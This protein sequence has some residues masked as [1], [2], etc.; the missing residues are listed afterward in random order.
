[1][2]D[3]FKDLNANQ[4]EA[5]T[6][7]EGRIRLVAGAG[8]GKTRTLAHRFAYLANELGISAS[9]IL[10]MTFTNKAA[11]EM[12]TRIARLVNSTGNVNDFV[13]TIHG[14]CVKVL[15][16]EIH[17]LGF[18]DN[19]VILDE[20]DG[21]E[22]AKQVIVDLGLDKS[23]TTAAKVLDTVGASKGDG[24]YVELMFP[25]RQLDAK[26]LFQRYLQLQVKFFAVDFDDLL[27]F[28]LY[29]FEH[30]ADARAY[31]QELIDYV[32]IDEAQDCDNLDWT[33]I[34]LLAAKN[35]NLLAVGDPDQAIYE[36]RGAKPNLFINFDADRTI[37]LNQNYRSTPDILDVANSVIAH[38]KNRIPKELFTR[39]L[40][41][42]KVIHYHGRSEADESAWVTRQVALLA[43]EAG[44]GYDDIAILFRTASLSRP[45]EQALIQ[46]KVPYV[47][48]GGVRFFERREIKDALGY[49]KLV[50]RRDDM[51]FRRVVN[52]PSR[53]FGRASLAKLTALAEAEGASL[54]DT[55]CR[56][57]GDKE[58][59]RPA[60][61]AFCDLITK[62]EELKPRLSVSE[63]L[64]QL[65]TESGLKDEI[66]NDEDQER[67]DNLNE[68]IHSVRDYETAHRDDEPTIEHYLQDIALYTNAD[69][70]SDSRRVRL[71]TIHQAKGLEFKYVFV[72]GLTEGVFPSHRSI[73]ERKKAAEEEE[74]RL[75]YVALTRAERALFLTESEGY[76]GATQGNKY[77][78]RFLSEIGESLVTVEGN[79]DP[80]LLEGTR[81]LVEG[82]NREIELADASA[83][84][85]PGARVRHKVFGEGR[86]IENNREKSSCYVDFGG[87]KLNL[88]YG[89]LTLVGD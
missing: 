57:Q 37:M 41:H 71:M 44:S 59:A 21:K 89:V 20:E 66:R 56:H 46:Q 77:P 45:F 5:V 36:W 81:A 60:I 52:V 61:K 14:F 25:G 15:R 72:V 1:M 23:K 28:T 43:G 47:I 18:P 84:F 67:L 24:S 10:C 39:A 40:P 6:A 19:F 13:C 79:L 2:T 55:L 31:W 73:R 65:L 48:W 9:N 29:I 30:F 88:V 49:L 64:E 69:Y 34:N 50:S 78:S 26:N 87:K 27:F 3:I 76:N 22:L 68:L 33:L 58:F 70:R 80:S 11:Q 51:A 38:N 63:L 62:Y 32:M 82:L 75:M 85:T 7:T 12:K 74:R 53:K 17:R 86:V 16:R 54:F 35:G 8:S 83:D 42:K 4:L